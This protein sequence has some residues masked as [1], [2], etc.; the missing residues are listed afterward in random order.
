MHSFNIT[1]QYHVKSD[2]TSVKDV[3]VARTAIIFVT[4]WG[5]ECPLMLSLIK[6]LKTQQFPKKLKLKQNLHLLYFG[7]TTHRSLRAR[8]SQFICFDSQQTPTNIQIAKYLF[9]LCT[10]C[11][12]PSKKSQH[13]SELCAAAAADVRL[14]Y[15]SCRA[16]QHKAL[17]LSREVCQSE[18]QTAGS[19]GP[20]AALWALMSSYPFTLSCFHSIPH[21]PSLSLLHSIP[22][23][24]HSS[25]D[26]QGYL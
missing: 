20:R 18:R 10:K 2:L 5:I 16:E 3:T 1:L 4:G 12:A 11:K 17:Q 21:S 25:K 19:R 9:L 13:K 15:Q 7:Q 26:M 6:I 24:S 23:R 8:L 14:W 22:I